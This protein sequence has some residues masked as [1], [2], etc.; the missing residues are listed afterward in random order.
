MFVVG[1]NETDIN[2]TKEVIENMRK[3]DVNIIGSIL[4]KYDMENNAY[5]Y[6]GYYYQQEDGKHGR[7]NKKKKKARL[8]GKKKLNSVR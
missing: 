3:S 5:G 8:F 4:N 1:A 6:Y 2:H 7:K